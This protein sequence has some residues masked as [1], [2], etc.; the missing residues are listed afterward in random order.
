MKERS[1]ALAVAQ[2]VDQ[3]P[4]DH[5]PVIPTDDS[6]ILTTML[7]LIALLVVCG[8]VLLSSVHRIACSSPIAET[9]ISTREP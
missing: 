1:P 6:A 3:E 9:L 2:S 7:P 8:A 5:E 4:W